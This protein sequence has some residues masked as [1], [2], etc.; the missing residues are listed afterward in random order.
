[1]AVNKR[2]A[3]WSLLG[4]AVA[5]FVGALVTDLVWQTREILLVA[6]AIEAVA[7]I[8]LVL[9]MVWPSPAFETG[10]VNPQLV[11]CPRCSSVFDPPKRGEEI[12]CPTCGLQASAPQRA[13][14]PDT[15]PTERAKDDVLS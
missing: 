6:I 3:G 5:T 2:L 11:R 15:A 10:D 1:M 4:V 9:L 12:T 14:S 13:A 8:G 7:L